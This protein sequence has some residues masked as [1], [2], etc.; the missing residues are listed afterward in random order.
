M[1]KFANFTWQGTFRAWRLLSWDLAQSCSAAIVVDPL[2]C[3]IPEVGT[4][5]GRSGRLPHREKDELG[6][7]LAYKEAAGFLLSVYTSPPFIAEMKL[8]TRFPRCKLVPRIAR[9][10][11]FMLTRGYSREVGRLYVR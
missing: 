10:S 2:S 4:A 1:D 11:I 7:N 9:A 5:Q 6:V 8:Q 3:H